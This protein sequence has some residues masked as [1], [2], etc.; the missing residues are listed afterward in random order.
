MAGLTGNQGVK[1][2]AR[3][4]V[5]VTLD[6]LP[7]NWGSG[8]AANI[9]NPNVDIYGTP[10]AIAGS[11]GAPAYTVNGVTYDRAGD[12]V[13]TSS[14][15]APRTSAND[16]TA[17]LGTNTGNYTG[18]GSTFDPNDVAQANDIIAQANNVL[19]R[20]GGNRQS[21]L[22]SINGTFSNYR[23]SLQNDYG[24]NEAD[25]NQN[26]VTTTRQ[27]EVAKNNI[28]RKVA[29]R[30]NSLS[31]YLGSRGAGDS[32]A[33]G[34]ANYA[35]ARTG[36]QLR[37]DVNQQYGANLSSLDQSFNRYKGDYENN[38]LS[39]GDQERTARNKTEADFLQQQYD[40]QDR[41]RQG[42]AA[43][44]YAQ[45]GNAAQAR[46]MREQAL[47]GLFAILQQIDAL[48]KPQITP[49]VKDATYSAPELS[50]YTTENVQDV[51]GIDPAQAD[52][53]SPLYQYLL[54]RQNEDSSFFGY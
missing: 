46:A 40:A 51:A 14:T 53:V 33:V 43:L 45:T 22:D 8:T 42:Q 28:D 35:A 44:N 54:K 17:V 7:G 32:S 29:T 31:R 11:R 10:T 36:T 27:N 5:G 1:G 23:N 26:K 4:F 3:N 48:S 34:L 49:T 20:L 15:P 38:L 50:N 9:A 16:S 25:Y 37:N 6:S 2:L 21:A 13:S 39:L 19:S 30:A 41:L 18:S 24:R 47:P 52:N 12:V